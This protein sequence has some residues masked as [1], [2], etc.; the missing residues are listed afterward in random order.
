M[1][2]YIYLRSFSAALANDKDVAEP[3]ILLRR[4]FGKMQSKNALHALEFHVA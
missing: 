1:Y 3:P 2:D 4:L